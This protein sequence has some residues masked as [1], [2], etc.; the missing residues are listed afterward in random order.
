MKIITTLIKLFNLIKCNN[1]LLNVIK[2]YTIFTH[3][4]ITLINKCNKKLCTGQLFHA[5]LNRSRHIFSIKKKCI[6]VCSMILLCYVMLLHLIIN[7][8]IIPF[9]YFYSGGLIY[10]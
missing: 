3:L 5:R 9:F 1:L 4:I 6:S 10:V 2:K 8:N 7:N